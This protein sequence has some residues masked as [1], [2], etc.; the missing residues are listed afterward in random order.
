MTLDPLTG[1][2]PLG[3]VEPGP[4][5]PA[6]PWLARRL[7]GFGCSELAALFVAL[8]LRAPDGLPKY[9]Q[10]DARLIF[11][12]KVTGR[13]KKAGAAA[14]GGSEAERE[15]LARWVDD[16]CPGT[17]VE[18]WTVRHSDD[19]PREWLP[20]VDRYEPRLLCT[21]DAWGRRGESLVAVEIKTTWERHYP[22]PWSHALQVQGEM[23]VMGAASGVIVAGP[24]WANG[25]RDAIEVWAIERDEALQA[26]IRA[27]CRLGWQRVEEMKKPC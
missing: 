12:R 1:M 15:L 24:G 19:V 16:G 11:R 9:T 17:D 20:L 7:L 13:Q 14:R 2:E 25:H 6:D 4:V 26:E 10:E 18:P 3:V 21:P 5:A 8:G 27:A 22:R 23:A